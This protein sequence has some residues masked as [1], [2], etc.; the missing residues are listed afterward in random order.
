MDYLHRTCRMGVC[1]TENLTISSSLQRITGSCKGPRV[2]FSNNGNLAQRYLGLPYFILWL[3]LLNLFK[4]LNLCTSYIK[5]MMN[6]FSFMHCN[7]YFHLVKDEMYH[8]TQLHLIEWNIPSFTSWKYL[9]HC[10]RKHSLLN[11]ADE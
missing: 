1:K 2:S 6:V 5:Q 3:F 9:Y 7:K 11:T 8:S 10:T 4:N